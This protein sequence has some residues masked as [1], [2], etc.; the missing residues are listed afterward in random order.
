VLFEYKV[1]THLA[2][3]GFMSN[4]MVW[5]QH[6]ELNPSV[7]DELDGNDDGDQMDDMVADIGRGCD[8][9]SADPLLEV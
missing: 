3:K 7:G 8:L 1:S 2:K 4:Y 6:R 5:H 9:G